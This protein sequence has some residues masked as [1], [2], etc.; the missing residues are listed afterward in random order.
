MFKKFLFFIS[1]FPLSIFCLNKY[2]IEI[3][4]DM[5]KKIIKG[6][7]NLTITN[8][9]EFP[10]KTLHFNLYPNGFKEGSSLFHFEDYLSRYIK[11][12]GEEAFSY[13]KIKSILL[14]NIELKYKFIS[15]E[16]SNL[17]DETLAEVELPQPLFPGETI[18]LIIIW[19]TKLHRYYL[20]S[21]YSRDSFFLM[22]WYPKL[23]VFEGGKWKSH[24]FH[25]YT[26][27]YG[28][29]TDFEIHFKVQK[30]YEIGSTGKIY[31]EMEENLKN[32]KIVAE[33]VHDIAIVIS[34]ELKKVKKQIQITKDNPVDIEIL[35]PSEYLYKI[36]KVMAILKG[37][38]DFYNEWVGPYLYSNFTIVFPTWETVH[39]EAGMEY[40]QLI[41]CGIKHFERKGSLE[42]EYV[43]AHEFGHQ[44]FYGF[45][46]SDEVEEPWLD[47]GFTTYTS[48]KFLEKNYPSY[49]VNLPLFLE[50]TMTKPLKIDSFKA[51]NLYY[52]RD[53]G[54]S[55]FKFL[56]YLYPKYEDYRI[57]AYNKPAMALKTLENYVGEEQMKIF[58]EDY[59]SS[60]SFLHP[61]TE[62]LI[63]L[64][65]KNFGMGW[66]QNFYSL[67]NKSQII[68]YEVEILSKNKF[69]IKKY[70]DIYLPLEVEVYFN[71]GTKEK[72]NLDLQ[73]N[74]STFSYGKKEIKKVILDPKGKIALDLNPKN[75]IAHSKTKKIP[76]LSFFFSKINLFF[77]SV[78]CWF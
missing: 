18:N 49:R 72:I 25:L 45:L 37:V 71:D 14:E 16:D 28:E 13:L 50:L 39:G 29:F 70:G 3:D 9:Y 55:S 17:K 60:F 63:D 31:E 5:D 65:E 15:S 12:F 56:G 78:I 27:F 42:L 6:N 8:T 22:Q 33:N 67:S 24:Q 62:D 44:Y 68:D 19:E 53:K 52:F 7:T 11:K 43:I 48:S 41:M 46:A 35:I 75:N 54:I 2:V 10:L 26:E 64:I 58:F 20:R 61:H 21:G 36:P 4:L 38:F 59:F 34:K 76:Y 30:E 77:L 32:V 40:P 57:Y 73:K 74:F 1:F 47:E 69:V 66:A 51:V 23:A